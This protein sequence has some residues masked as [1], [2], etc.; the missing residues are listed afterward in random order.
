[1]VSVVIL[2]LGWASS[3]DFY[4]NVVGA[5]VIEGS[6][7]GIYPAPLAAPPRRGR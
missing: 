7:V 4:R 3:I 2:A 5:T 6:K 1:M